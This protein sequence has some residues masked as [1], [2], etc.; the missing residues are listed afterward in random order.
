MRL[1]T[2]IFVRLRYHPGTIASLGRLIGCS[3]LRRYRLSV[4]LIGTSRR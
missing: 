4:L 1:W 2:V 3:L